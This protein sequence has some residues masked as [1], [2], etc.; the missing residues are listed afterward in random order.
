MAG[1]H[2]GGD[3]L[4]DHDRARAIMR[5]Q[6]CRPAVV[7]RRLGALMM[8]LDPATLPARFATPEELDAFLAR[9]SH[10][11][12][13]DLAEVEGDIMVLGAG[14]KMGPTLA[15]LARNAAPDKR[16]IAVSRFSDPAL[17][18]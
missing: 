12:I 13:A 15:R 14:G 10:A 8:L 3:G 1:V 4:P 11:L 2:N 16:I 17:H 7:V 9:P 6:R 18:R 5:R